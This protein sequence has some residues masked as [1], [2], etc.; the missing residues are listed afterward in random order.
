M[1]PAPRAV[2]RGTATLAALLAAA[3]L[4][5]CGADEGVDGDHDDADVT[6]AT[7][8]IPHHRQAITMARLAPTRAASPQVKE[9]AGQIDAE[10][11]PE[12]VQM[13]TMLATWGGDAEQTALPADPHGMAGT[14]GGTD[15]GG[16]GDSGG[17][18]RADMPGMATD[19][20]LAELSRATG[21]A[22]DREFLDLMIRHHEGAVG[23]AKTELADGR[24]PDALTMARNISDAQEAAIAL[25]QRLQA[26]P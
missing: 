3:V 10:Q 5:G 14:G 15:S 12:I 16:G 19:A 24:D 11:V 2:R 23:M 18:D 17:G 4:A 6:F 7:M 13:Q 8:M 9:L 25:M 26:Q 20:Q 1:A 21:P 22:F